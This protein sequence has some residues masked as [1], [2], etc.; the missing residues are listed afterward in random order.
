LIVSG[1]LVQAVGILL[2]VT[3]NG[4]EGWMA[5]AILLGIGTALVYPT[6]LAAV[7][8]AAHPV[9]RASAVGVYR[10]WRDGGYAVGGFLA[11]AL[12][13]TLGMTGTFAIVAGITA[14]S[15]LVVAV[16]MQERRQ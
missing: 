8:D 4:L 10:L 6:L 2:F 3:D 15:G 11:G 5:G 13:D 12:A 1:M 16:L 9:W 14:A 7:S